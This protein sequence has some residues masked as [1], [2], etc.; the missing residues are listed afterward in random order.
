MQKVEAVMLAQQAKKISVLR[1]WLK[2]GAQ[3]SEMGWI[4]HCRNVLIG[5][6]SPLIGKWQYSC[7]RL[8]V[9]K[10][11][12]QYR[13]IKSHKP[14]R[15]P[16]KAWMEFDLVDRIAFVAGRK[17]NKHCLG[18][19]HIAINNV[20]AGD[21]PVAVDEPSLPQHQLA[22]AFIGHDLGQSRS[23]PLGIVHNTFV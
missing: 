15:L 2:G 12:R 20:P 1:K 14:I 18:C 4:A 21:K 17:T 8:R 10:P 23:N 7:L 6:Q 5:A 22:W 11:H 16:D 9:P 19:L 3:L 13:R